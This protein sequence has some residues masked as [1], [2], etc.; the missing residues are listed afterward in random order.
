VYSRC[1][2]NTDEFTSEE[3]NELTESEK[4]AHLD[5]AADE[6]RDNAEREGGTVGLDGEVR[7]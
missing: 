4:R 7:W 2:S 1:M 3:W 5:A 6:A